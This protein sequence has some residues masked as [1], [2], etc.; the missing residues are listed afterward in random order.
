M[1][2]GIASFVAINIIHLCPFPKNIDSVNCRFVYSFSWSASEKV[3]KWGQN[4]ASG[5]RN[6]NRKTPESVYLCIT[7]GIILPEWCRTV[8]RN[9]IP[10]I[11]SASLKHGAPFYG[12]FR[13]NWLLRYA[14]IKRT[15]AWKYVKQ[16]LYTTWKHGQAEAVNVALRKVGCL[17]W[18]Q[19]ILTVYPAIATSDT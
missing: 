15:V 5:Q 16:R 8:P 9:S 7:N 13:Y 2:S 19:I 18:M 3:W 4:K 10:F 6:Q 17:G 11:C 12:A 14:P 1:P